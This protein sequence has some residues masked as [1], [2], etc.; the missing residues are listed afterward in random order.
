MSDEALTQA[1]SIITLAEAEL[2]A[3]LRAAEVT[4]AGSPPARLGAAWLATMSSLDWP[5]KGYAAFFRAVTILTTIRLVSH[6]ALPL[7]ESPRSSSRI[8]RK[9]PFD[10]PVLSFTAA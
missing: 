1:E 9:G 6:T 3:F 7:Q 2:A 8:S 4:L 5:D 10:A